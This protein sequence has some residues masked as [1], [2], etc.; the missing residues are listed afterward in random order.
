YLDLNSTRAWEYRYPATNSAWVGGN[1]LAYRKS[2]WVNHKFAD[3]QVGEDSRF[4]W[5]AGSNCIRDLM[6]PGLCVATAHAGNTSRKDVNGAYWHPQ[7]FDRIESLLGHDIYFYLA[8]GSER[9]WPL[10]SCIMPTFNRRQYVTEALRS[11][12]QQD[13]PNRE[14]IVVDDGSDAIQD[15][16]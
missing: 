3:I 1:T 14:L 10:V 13:Y 11:F 6:Q 7:S 4:V 9:A 16:I 15:L 5:S 12:Q 8:A 2:F